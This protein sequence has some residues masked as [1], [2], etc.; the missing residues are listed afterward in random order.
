MK[1]KGCKL[2]LAFNFA[3]HVMPFLTGLS[4]TWCNNP[5]DYHLSNNRCESHLHN[6]FHGLWLL[7][8]M[9]QK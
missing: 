4:Y 9:I 8:N 5:Q 7:Q 6:N 3:G 1:N 2:F